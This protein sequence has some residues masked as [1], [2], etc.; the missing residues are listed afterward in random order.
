ME[1]QWYLKSDGGHIY[2]PISLKTLQEWVY[3]KRV[4]GKDLVSNDRGVHWEKAE[5]VPELMD[6]FP[7]AMVET[8]SRVLAP[9]VKKEKRLLFEAIDLTPLVDI[10]FTL[11]LFFIVT[12]TF[13]TQ[14]TVKIKLPKATASNEEVVKP[15]IVSVSKEGRIY[16]NGKLMKLDELEKELQKLAKKETTLL[17]RADESTLHGKVVRVM[18]MAKKAGISRLLVACLEK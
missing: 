4:E 7:S 5:R 17:V 14:T 6:F 15:L 11:L 3:G 12:A 16:L 18:D 13:N 10:I 2:G 8:K 1:N 9:R